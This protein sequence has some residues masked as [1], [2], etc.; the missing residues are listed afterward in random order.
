MAKKKRATFGEAVLESLNDYMDRRARGEKLTVQRVERLAPAPAEFG[1][2]EII[3][4][5]RK[6]NVSQHVFATVL[7]A[8]PATVRA[9]EQGAKA[10]A[11]MARR[12]LE[13]VDAHPDTFAKLLEKKRVA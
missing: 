8:S 5:R 10:P 6:L 3:S 11:P 2:K 7:G 4:I 13:V 1:P 9:W 12:L